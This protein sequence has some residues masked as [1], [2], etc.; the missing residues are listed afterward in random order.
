MSASLV[1][2]EMCIRDSCRTAAGNAPAMSSPVSPP[3]AAG[4]VAP[5]APEQGQQVPPAGH[6]QV[7]PIGVRT[8]GVRQYVTLPVSE[9]EVVV[10]IPK[11]YLTMPL[12][13]KVPAPEFVGRMAARLDNFEQMG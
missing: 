11:E 7:P 3:D 13:T 8:F 12:R 10:K 5:M 2:S 4:H 6:P 1:G 9:Y